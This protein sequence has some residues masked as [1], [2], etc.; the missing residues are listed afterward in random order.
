MTVEEAVRQ[1]LAAGKKQTAIAKECGVSRQYVHQVVRKLGM[2]STQKADPGYEAKVEKAMRWLKKHGPFPQDCAKATGC[3]LSVVQVA[4]RRAGLRASMFSQ[5]V[6]NQRQRAVQML[7][8]TSNSHLEIAKET[9]LTVRTVCNLASA[10]H[11]TRSH[12]HHRKWRHPEGS[13]R[14]KRNVE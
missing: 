3:D 12:G 8:E 7:K 14:R 11:L 1:G 6:Y 13:K 5:R 2:T 4:M 10:N 9:R